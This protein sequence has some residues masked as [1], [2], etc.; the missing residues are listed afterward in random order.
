MISVPLH[1]RSALTFR[2]VDDGIRSIAIESEFGA[3]FS[4]TLAQSI[5]EVSAR[6]PCTGRLPMS[7]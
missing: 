1:W 7:S 2:L 6:L 5:Y 4:I 3:R